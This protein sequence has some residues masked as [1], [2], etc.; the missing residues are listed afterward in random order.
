MSP[1]DVAT[2]AEMRRTVSP[3]RD[4]SLLLVHSP[5]VGP[6]SWRQLAAIAATHGIDVIR[7]DLTT[8]AEA[9]SPKWRHFV[10]AAVEAVVDR[11][12]LVVVGHS[13]AGAMLPMI[14]D[15]IGA[16]LTA[17]VFVDAVIPPPHGAHATP[18]AFR[19][20]LEDKA[21]NG[22]LPRWLDW[23]PEEDVIDLLLDATGRA[24]LY[25]DMP[26]LPVSF[27]DEDVPVPK[28][29]STGPCAYLRLSDAYLDEY[30]VAGDAGWPRSIVNGAHLSI[31]TDSVTVFDA[32]EEL[33][34]EVRQ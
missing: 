2:T 18:E 30:K 25:A 20:F 8:I 9:S 4:M 7:P 1:T 6:S 24:E 5:L 3:M 27:Y 32:I 10:D 22:L 11:E 26:Q 12:N 21:K 29:W 13:G 28:G 16:R 14:A 15:G 33:V 31:S 23:W 34:N 19:S 17:L